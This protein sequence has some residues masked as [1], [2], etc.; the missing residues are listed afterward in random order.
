MHYQHERSVSSTIRAGWR[1]HVRIATRLLPHFTATTLNLA[2]GHVHPLPV[3]N[4]SFSEQLRG[5]NQG[6]E[7]G[8]HRILRLGVSIGS[9]FLL[10]LAA[11]GGAMWYA[12]PGSSSP[13]PSEPF[14]KGLG[15]YSRTVT[16]TSPIAQRYFDQGLA[17]LYG[18]NHHEAIRSFEAAARNDPN[19]AMA[20]WGIA[21]ANGP[22][23]N[24]MEPNEKQAT[25]AWNA[26]AKATALSL[27]GRT[28]PIEKAMIDAA[29]KRYADSPRA[30]RRLLD[31]AYVA[32]MRNVSQEYPG[33]A[34]A[35]ALTAEALLDLRPW[36]QW[37][38]DGKAQ[39]GTE[40]IIRTLA[41]VLEKSPSHPFALHLTVHA[42][43]ASPHPE[44]ADAAA[45][46]LRNLEPGNE[47]LLHVASHIDIRLGR[48]RAAVVANEMAIAA[49][50]AYQQITPASGANC[51]WITHDY[52][53]LAYAASMSGESNKATRA[54]TKMNLTIADMNLTLSDN[55]IEDAEHFTDILAAMPYELHL[56]FGR[57]D[58]M[59]TEPHSSESSP[60][61]TALWHYARAVAFAAKNQVK[62][63]SAEQQAFLVAQKMIMASA[64]LHTHAGWSV[65]PVAEKMMQGEILY[66]EGK[67]DQAIAALRESV[68]REDHLNYI[69]PPY[70]MLHVRHA[71]GAVLLHSGRPKDAEAVY[72]DDL[73]R[74]PENGWS[75]WGLSHS[76]RMQGKQ[77][78]AYA[79]AKRFDLAWRDADLKLSS[80][81]CCLPFSVSCGVPSKTE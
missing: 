77:K 36:D 9:M 14:F 16:T 48:W 24:N 55:S 52:H 28:S 39:P 29:S 25:S 74:H 20:F 72:R 50:D 60:I 6:V 2:C 78:E 44:R 46:R 17:F 59:L 26:I 57:W 65:L 30:D 15:T 22:H 34:D 18:F 58:A 54:I 27:D 75:L 37:T 76:L 3:G 49:D 4:D 68:R 45:E 62:E 8:I 19:C 53:M 11:V 81:C 13:T 41:R 40:E 66:R 51:V 7:S 33:D 21:M 35:G 5:S 10:A 64:D 67:V 61:A 42:M 79:I 1:A 38:R 80:S 63:A 71:L 70:W 43:E 32:A 31:R 69:E 23:I 56:R 73:A 12:L 47:H